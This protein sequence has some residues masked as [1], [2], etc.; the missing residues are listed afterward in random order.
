MDNDDDQNH[1]S[2]LRF[3][4]LFKIIKMLKK[5][6]KWDLN[7][8]LTIVLAII[9]FI[10]LIIIATPSNAQTQLVEKLGTNKLS[11]YEVKWSKDKINTDYFTLTQSIQSGRLARAYTGIY[12]DYNYMGTHNIKAYAVWDK[13]KSLIIDT[14]SGS[15]LE[16]VITHEQGHFD[17]TE[18]ITRCLNNELR[19]VSTISAADKLYYLYLDKLDWMQKMYDLQTDHHNN[20]PTQL[21]WDGMILLLLTNEEFAKKPYRIYEARE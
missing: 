11:V 19:E 18:Y 10:A 20:K 21:V 15:E 17:I 13:S 16:E 2:C 8:I 6:S 7:N 12:M 3:Y 9:L 4:F 14:L 5:F 1:N